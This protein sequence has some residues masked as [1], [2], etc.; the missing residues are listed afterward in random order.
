MIAFGAFPAF[1]NPNVGLFQHFAL[2]VSRWLEI[3]NFSNIRINSSECLRMISRSTYRIQRIHIDWLH[4][5]AWLYSIIPS[6]LSLLF[7]EYR[8]SY[9]S[10]RR[11]FTYLLRG[12]N[13]A[14][15]AAQSGLR[16]FMLHHWPLRCGST[17]AALRFPY[18]HRI[19]VFRSQIHMARQKEKTRVRTS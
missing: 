17:C 15:S 13:F 12:S 4:W 3:S 8:S 16:R 18:S 11:T 7:G 10:Y 6:L 19:L 14:T 9:L 1:R 5:R 2:F